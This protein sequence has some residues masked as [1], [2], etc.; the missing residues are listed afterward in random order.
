MYGEV[1]LYS[2]YDRNS[3]ESLGERG[4][5]TYSDE[6]KGFEATYI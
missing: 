3:S 4:M 5:Q 1:P 2:D 6:K